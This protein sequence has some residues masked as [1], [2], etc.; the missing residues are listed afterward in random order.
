PAAE[1]NR[2]VFLGDQITEKWG[3]GAKVFP[4]QPYF[5]RGI[6]AQTTPQMLVRFRQD[7]IGLKAR[8]VVIQGGTNNIAGVT[9]PS[10][11]ATT[12]DE[13]TPMTERAAATGIRVVLASITPVCDCVTDQT[14]QRSPV[15]I[16]DVNG[17]IRDY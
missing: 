17:W 14:S 11:R 8:V 13:L 3:G 15:R 5:N 12:G 4:G 16:A 1:E 10:T 6:S 2:V 7:V 9:G